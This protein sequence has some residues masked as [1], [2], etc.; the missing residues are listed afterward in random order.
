[1]MNQDTATRLRRLSQN[2]EAAQQAFADAWAAGRPIAE[3]VEAFAAASRERDAL[4][5]EIRQRAFPAASRLLAA[6][7]EVVALYEEGL[8]ARTETVWRF[9]PLIATA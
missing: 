7:A 1:M 3:A 6:E 8:T 4:A 2:A 5:E 9:A